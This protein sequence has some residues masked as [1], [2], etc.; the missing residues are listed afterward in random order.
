MQGILSCNGFINEFETVVV[1]MVKLSMDKKA[2]QGRNP[3]TGETIEI[4]AERDAGSRF[5]GCCHRL[6]WVDQSQ[7]VSGNYDR[8]NILW[9]QTIFRAIEE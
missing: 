6:L 2:R 5:A 3:R 8:P 7:S 1:V 9:T 4:A